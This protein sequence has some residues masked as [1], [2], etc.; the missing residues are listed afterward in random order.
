M[1]K[2]GMG[3]LLIVLS[4]AVFLP[5]L[6]FMSVFIDHDA[7]EGMRLREMLESGNW[8]FPEVLRKPPLYYWMSGAV[9]QL[10]GGT[11][12]AL[13]LRLPSA[14]LAGLGVVIVFGLGQ[15]AATPTGGALAGVILLTSLLYVQQGHSIRTDM[16]LC[17][18]VTC[19]LLL[20]FSAYSRYWRYG[21]G[22]TWASLLFACSLAL[23]LLSKGPVGV[24][25]VLL[26]IVAFLVW[27]HDLAGAR[28]L[29]RPGPLLTFGVLGCGWYV[30]ALWGAREEFWH[31]QIMEENVSRFVGGIDKMSF[32][33]Y[34]GPLLLR[35]APWIL[36]LPA[37]LWRAFKEKAEGPVFLALWWLAVVLFF[38]LAAY[39]RSRYLLPAQPASALLV[40]WWLA[41]RYF[42]AAAA[43][44][45]WRWWRY[46][47]GLFSVTTALITIAG[48]IVLWGT[49]EGGPLPCGR[50]LSRVVRETPEQVDLYCHWLATHFWGSLAWWGLLLLCLF[51]LGWSLA[52]VRLQRALAWLSAALLLVYGGLY[53]SWLVVTS[54]AQSPQAFVRGIVDKIGPGRQVAFINP[55]AEKGLPVVFSLQ[56]QAR[57]T[58]VRW[59]WETPP[60]PLPTGYYLVSDDRRAEVTSRAPGTWSE[61]LRDPGPPG[62]PLALFFYQAP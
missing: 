15:H 46:G 23:A 50:L 21:R 13:S 37:A 55:F 61:V 57:V 29:L 48:S 1:A 7:L 54:W 40:G 56:E 52:Q 51:S 62:W 4:M 38:Q 24:I 18:F 33:Y 53:P 26:P 31:A 58:E 45:R 11:V 6:P 44:K 16:A 10:H 22:E 47:V 25:L 32:F 2:R 20:F 8:F 17:F 30:T 12:D 59:P 35:F 34:L 39:K 3:A 9:A 28:P 14:L 42:P 19:S 43:V 5:S 27:R 49:R 36:F 60:P 41:T